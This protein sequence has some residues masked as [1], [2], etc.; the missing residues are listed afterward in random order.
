MKYSF[1]IYAVQ[2]DLQQCAINEH[3]CQFVVLYSLLLHCFTHRSAGVPFRPFV[4]LQARSQ[5]FPYITNRG[6]GFVLHSTLLVV[7]SVPLTSW[8]TSLEDRRNEE[9]VWCNRS[10][11]AAYKVMTDKQARDIS[12]HFISDLR[13]LLASQRPARQAVRYP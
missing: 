13:W 1:W 5:Q 2:A 4:Y 12:T 10:F 3:H 8:R 9:V 7:F 6:T 11:E